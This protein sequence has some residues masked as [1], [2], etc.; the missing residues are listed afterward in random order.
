LNSATQ[1]ACYIKPIRNASN[2]K[3]LL[4]DEVGGEVT[5]ND[6]QS[7]N[8]LN[9]ANL[10]CDVSFNISNTSVT[11]LAYNNIDISN[12]IYYDTSNTSYIRFSQTGVYKIGTSVQFARSSANSANVYLWFR[13]ASGN[14]SNS[15]SV[16][17]LNGSDAKSFNY[18][19]IIYKVTNIS[20]QYVEV[21][22]KASDTGIL[23]LA[24]A[25]VSP[26][27]VVP[28]IIT[29]VIQIQ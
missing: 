7:I 11:Q 16:I 8:Y 15:A 24:L 1:N 22:A 2:S 19:E 12:G 27:P 25:A 18:V 29:T 10:S 4:Y 17:N 26:V 6:Y 3:V 13:D 23:A 20:T 5:Y 28:S 14:I 9:Y 21:V